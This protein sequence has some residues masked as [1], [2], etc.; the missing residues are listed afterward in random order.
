MVMGCL[1]CL[2]EA[3]AMRSEPVKEIIMVLEGINVLLHPQ[4]EATD[5]QVVAVVAI[6]KRVEGGAEV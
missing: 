3:A 2:Q 5:G 4:C 1:A 6:Q